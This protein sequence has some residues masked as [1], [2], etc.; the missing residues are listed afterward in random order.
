MTL[1][2]AAAVCALAVIVTHLFERL[3]MFPFMGWG[4]PRTPGHYLDLAS[5]ILAA[6]FLCAGAFRYFRWN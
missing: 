4:Q 6:I 2:K 3:H 5:A 1:F